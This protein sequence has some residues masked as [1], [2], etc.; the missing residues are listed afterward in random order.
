VVAPA[1]PLLFGPIQLSPPLFAL[2]VRRDVMAKRHIAVAN[3][4]EIHDCDETS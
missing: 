3:T 1:V 4:I 2:F